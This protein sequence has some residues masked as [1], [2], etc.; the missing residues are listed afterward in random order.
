MIVI[1]KL[2][3][4][5]LAVRARDMGDEELK[6]LVDMHDH[7]EGELL[8][9]K[10]NAINPESI[11]ASIHRVIDE[12]ILHAAAADEKSQAVTCREGCA[13]CCKLNVDIDQNEGF[14][15]L[16]AAKEKG[17]EIDWARVKRQASHTGTRWHDQPIIDRTCVFLGEDNRCGVYEFR[18]S[19]CRRYFALNDPDDCDA[20]KHPAGHVVL[21]WSPVTVEIVASASMVVNGDLAALPVMLQRARKAREKK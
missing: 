21:N 2:M 12:H 1:K 15:L 6:L 4:D 7:Y 18:P 16:E 17:I 3:S 10:R 5:K 11:A 13:H 19:A 9:V 14:L 20:I 8:R